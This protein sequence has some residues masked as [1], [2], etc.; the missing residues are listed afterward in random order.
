MMNNPSGSLPIPIEVVEKIIDIVGETRYDY[1]HTFTENLYS[2]W[3]A[4]ALTCRAMTPRSQY[5]LFRHIV[6]SSQSQA[7]SLANL[8]KLNPKVGSY[9][10]KLSISTPETQVGWISWIP[11]LL[12]PRLTNLTV[13]RLEG[14]LFSRAHTNLITSL[15]SFKS[16][17]KLQLYNVTF[18]TLAAFVRLVQAFPRL[19][20]LRSLYTTWKPHPPSAE[21]H[22]VPCS[23]D[24]KLQVSHL[25]VWNITYYSPETGELLAWL[26]QVQDQTTLRAL[27]FQIANNYLVG[28]VLLFSRHLRTFF[29]ELNGDGYISGFE[30]LSQLEVLH[31]DIDS[32]N[33]FPEKSLTSIITSLP[34]HRLRLLVIYIR[35]ECSPDQ[36]KEVDDK[37][38]EEAI[39]NVDEGLCATPFKE[40]K[41]TVSLYGTNPENALAFWQS[42][43]P[44]LLPKFWALKRMKV[45]STPEQ[46]PIRRWTVIYE[47]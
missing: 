36:T 18:S 11:L 4:C 1:N 29:L 39:N 13:L 6:L 27:G 15:S 38:E 44:K 3:K 45:E 17:K 47:G 20:V 25:D 24:R 7:T 9:T 37:E 30:I 12:A 21:Y 2:T 22:P 8:L 32:T 10:D 19:A 40:L 16:V 26:H 42:K 46:E 33:I 23:R 5:W 14:N 34:S 41:L 28:N 35:V 31:L 43:I